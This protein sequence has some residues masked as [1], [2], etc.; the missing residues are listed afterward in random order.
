MQFDI[1]RSVT[2]PFEDPQW[3]QKLLIFLVV[4]FVP[5][6]NIILWS[7]YA[8]TTARN[9]AR[10]SDLPLPGWGD[11]ADIAV[12]GLLSIA[13]TA[14]YLIP[15]LFLIGCLTGV[16][17]V[18]GGRVGGGFEALRC[19]GFALAAL[20]SLLMSYVLWTGHTRFAQRDQFASYVTIGERL[21]DA[22]GGRAVFGM[23][24]LYETLLTFL[25]ILLSVVA[26][27]LFLFA[28]SVVAT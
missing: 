8:V 27:A 9:I 24:F 21:R 1:G 23:L 5:G 22:R 25:L 18:L 13:A 20:Y 11:W 19:V 17:L 2:Y 7:G 14:F 10:G 15:A 26:G 6:L 12:R 3:A 4:G 28:L 16:S